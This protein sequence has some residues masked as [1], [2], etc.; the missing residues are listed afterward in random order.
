MYKFLKRFFDIVVS[1]TAIV[2][3]SWLLLLLTLFVA[4]FLGRPVVFK[5]PRPGK[6]GKIFMLYKF[7]SM[8][9]KKDENGNLLPDAQRITKFGK[10]LRVS[11]LDELPQLFNILKGDMSLIGPRPRMI[12]ECVFLNKDQLTRFEVRPGITG[13]AQINGR[14][15]ITFDTVVEFD[16]E[17][18]KNLSFG[19][20]VK[21]FFKT[22][23]YVLSKKDVNKTGTVSNEFYGDYLLRTKQIS[24]EVYD[25][26]LVIA[27]SM[28]KAVLDK[29]QFKSIKKAH[30]EINVLTSQE[31]FDLE[32]KIVD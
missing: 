17:Y 19:Q 7:R 16:K 26:K 25:E 9:N 8:T 11:S 1:F 2:C 13:L 24:Q 5:Q 20:D 14:N 15:N 31:D 4:I 22:F 12:E 3:F 23:G 6:N 30:K 21:I 27:K 29:K 18:V 32:R 28:V 10:F